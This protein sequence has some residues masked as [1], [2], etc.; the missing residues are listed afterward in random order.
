MMRLSAIAMWTH[1]H[2]HGADADVTGIAID[3]RKVKQGDLFVAF[4]GERVDG[5]NYLA[6]AKAR[7]AVAALVEHRVESDLPQVEV[8]SAELALGDL[9]SAVRAQRNARVIGITGSNGKTTVKTLIA[10]ILS[11]HGRTHVNTGSYNNEIG[12]P[13]TLLWMPEDTEY[14]V[15]EMGAG[16][17]GDIDYLAAIARPDIGLVNII[18]PA[19]L[20]RMGTIEMVAETKG[21]VYRALP[22]DGVAVINADDA[23]A[24]FFMG[25]AGGRHILRFGLDHK[26]DVGAEILEQRVDGSHFVLS[27]PHGDA[28]VQLPLPGRHNI[29]NALAAS[30]IALAL[31]VPLDTIVAGLEQASAVEGRLKRI[32]MPQGWT[33]IDDSYNANPSSMHAAIDTLVLA[34]GERWLVLGDM[35]ELGAEAR[36]L[37][38]GVGRHAHERGIDRLF[39]VGPLSAAAV[40]AFGAGGRHFADKATLIDALHAELHAGVTCLVKGSHSSGMEQVVAALKSGDSK[41]GVHNAA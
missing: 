16:K 38:A 5:H 25:L 19:H 40:E 35:A 32:D 8:K 1:G 31:D 18:A 39:A 6:D 23:F 26:A 30:A 17:P 34:A 9:A 13:L 24:S 4:K 33:L 21:A 20:E 37:H 41:G 14:A 10:S 7:G 29:A 15:L 22:A 11:R 27:T 28:D 3:S 12:L 36:A 2:M